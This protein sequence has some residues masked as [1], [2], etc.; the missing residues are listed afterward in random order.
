MKIIQVLPEL[1]S[2]GVERGTLELSR[3]LVAQGH[4]SL[5]ISNGG[6]LVSTLEAEDGTH[7]TLPVHRKSLRSLPQILKLRGVF[8]DLQPNI[9]H[10]RSRLPAWLTWLAWQGLKPDRR[11]RLISTV[12]GFYSVNRYSRIMTQGDDVICVS[13]SI[14]DYVLENYPGVLESRLHVVHRGVDPAELPFGYQPDAEWRQK[15]NA[16]YPQLAGRYVLTLPGRMTRLK[17]HLDFVKVLGNLNRAG[18]PASGLVVGDVHPKKREFEQ[19]VRDAVRGAGLDD[20]VVFTGHRSDVREIM[21][22][23]DVVLSCST[24]PESFGRVTLEALSLGKPVAAYDHG[25]VTEQLEELMPEGRVPV[26]DTDALTD[27]LRDWYAQRPAPRQTTD[28][29]FTLDHFWKGTLSVYE[30]AVQRRAA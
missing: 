11:P 16:D 19:E 10:V 17:G 28:H 15:W 13:R 18:I 12:H 30:N 3:F 7:I 20:A 1:N 4:E 8:Q 6:R 14:R 21:A 2:G 24:Q 29:S 22:V 26:G 5:V 25:G 9:V 23:S 27:L